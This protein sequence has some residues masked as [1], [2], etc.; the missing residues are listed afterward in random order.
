MTENSAKAEESGVIKEEVKHQF[1]FYITA[2]F[3]TY[4][5]SYFIPSIIFAAYIILVFFPFVLM[6]PTFVELFTS[7]ESIIALLF[8][9]LVLILCYIIRMYVVA[10]ISKIIWNY[11]ERGSPS[12]E[13]IIPRNI[14]SKTL[15]FYHIRSFLIK[16]PKNL[17]M[18]GL[19][20]W[21]INWLYNFIG[22]NKVGKGVTI[23]E[24]FGADRFVEFG[25]N[26]YIGVNSGFSSHAVDGSFGNISYF[27]IKLDKNVTAGGMNCV[28]PGVTV[29]ANSYLFPFA[30]ATK[31]NHLKGNNYYYG[32]PLRKIFKKKITEYSSIPKEI[33]EEEQNYQADPQSFEVLKK[34]ISENYSPNYS[35]EALTQA[36]TETPQL[37]PHVIDDKDNFAV[38]FSTSSSINRISLK[39]LFLYLPIFL[40]S[41]LLAG[42]FWEDMSFI[43][44]LFNMEILY[45]CLLP[46]IIFATYN[47]FY[48]FCVILSKLFLIFINL[49]H[50][51]KEGI[52]RAKKGNTDFE[53][54]RLRTELKKLVLW[55]SNNYPLPWIDA[56]AF[57][58]FGIKMNFSSHLPDAWVDAE[59][60]KLGRKVTVGQGAVV[61]S[62]MIVGNYLIIKKVIFED[63]AVIGGVSTVSPGTYVGADTVLG[64]LSVTNYNQKLEPGWIYFGIPVIKLKP[65]KYAEMRR[66]LIVKKDVDKRIKYT[67]ETEVNIDEDKKILVKSKNSNS[68]HSNKGE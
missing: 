47:M 41:G 3:I 19:F 33:I 45:I 14:P 22:S 57:R 52:F 53:F 44:N 55:I 54:W 25:D 63:Y 9:P 30:G 31:F 65:N 16:Y 64:A 46:V 48:F 8:T 6:V 34:V 7:L 32:V 1:K 39:F 62:S 40:A 59:F 21:A 24:Q 17:F 38:D 36:E 27:K 37:K 50:R 67:T 29:G 49:I 13:G 61:M 43:A 56:L 60:I 18:K 35:L 58:W 15:N 42:M 20:P 23:E 26:S 66:D 5:L 51:P 11:T 4:L 28:A 68:E 12:K 10:S 2:F